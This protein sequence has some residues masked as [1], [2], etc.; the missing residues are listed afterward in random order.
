M[1]IFQDVIV[2]RGL[3]EVQGEVAGSAV[4]LSVL[5]CFRVLMALCRCSRR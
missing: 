3:D 2:A 1:F 4:G 5:F